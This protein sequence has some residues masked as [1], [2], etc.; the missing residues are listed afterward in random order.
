MGGRRLITGGTDTQNPGLKPTHVSFWEKAFF[1]Q[2]A[3]K[4]NANDRVQS[5]LFQSDLSE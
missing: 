3:F 1:N 2:S 5:D 4:A